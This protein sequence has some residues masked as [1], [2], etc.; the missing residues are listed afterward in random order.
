MIILK[1]TGSDWG[2]GS[3]REET[4]EEGT[5]RGASPPHSLTLVWKQATPEPL[6]QPHLH[7]VK[8]R[9]E[10]WD[11]PTPGEWR[12]ML[13]AGRGADSVHKRPRSWLSGQR[14]RSPAGAGRTELDSATPTAE[15]GLQAEL[16]L[17]HHLLRGE[18]MCSPEARSRA[19][20]CSL[21]HEAQGTTQSHPPEETR[22]T[23][24]IHGSYMTP[25]RASPSME[26]TPLQ[27]KG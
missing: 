22:D 5:S 1:A 20:L 6:R 8:N 18:K 14:T 27:V 12:E 15:A 21:T 2:G 17:L 24:I 11:T 7:S 23:A 25:N 3:W 16:S 13:R 4:W 10:D 9:R 26:Q 19:H